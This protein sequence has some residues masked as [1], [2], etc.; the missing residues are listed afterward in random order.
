MRK[1]GVFLALLAMDIMTFA[2]NHLW[3]RLNSLRHLAT[4]RSCVLGHLIGSSVY[5][6]DWKAYLILHMH[7]ICSCTWYCWNADTSNELHAIIYRCKCLDRWPYM[8]N[9]FITWRYSV[10]QVHKS[11]YYI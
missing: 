5:R 4:A 11:I 9:C 10:N 2:R 1:H 7:C 8:S 6:L 3:K